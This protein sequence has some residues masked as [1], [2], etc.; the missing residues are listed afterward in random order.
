MAH[1][2][3]RQAN[4][5]GGI[6]GY[7]RR[8]MWLEVG[9]SNNNPSIIAKYFIDCICQVNGF[10]TLVRGD[11]G[12]ENVYIS[13]IQS[14]LTGSRNTR[15]N[16]QLSACKGFLYG[17]SV[18]NQRIEAWWSLLRKSNSSW[19]MNYFKDMC[20]SEL[21]DN[22]D[23]IQQNCLQFSFMPLIQKELHQVIK[24]W[25]LHNIRP[26]RNSEAPSG[27][28][29]VLYFLPER[30]EAVDYKRVADPTD[31]QAAE[32]TCRE[33]PPPHGCSTPFAQLAR[34]LMLEHNL[35]EPNNADEAKEL[36]T[37]L[38]LYIDQI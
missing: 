7:S 31:L 35:L 13:A 12:T 19:W 29:D 26:S 17:K 18:A 21:F 30:A 38:L 25:N 24:L 3:I 5:Y 9:P 10:P 36:F 28:P 34:I 11:C 32:S 20:D 2:W 6:D 22:S 23:T 37:L 4:G 14:Y 27:R 15:L 16:G 8:I 33:Q 1:R